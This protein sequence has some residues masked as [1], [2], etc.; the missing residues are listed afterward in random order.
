LQNTVSITFPA[1]GVTLN[2]LVEG[3]LGCIHCTEA[4]LSSEETIN[5][6][7]GSRKRKLTLDN[8]DPEIM[9]EKKKLEILETWEETKVTAFFLTSLL[10]DI[11]TLPNWQ[12]CL[13]L[14][15]EF[16]I[17]EAE[18]ERQPTCVP[19]ISDMPQQNIFP[20]ETTES[21]IYSNIQ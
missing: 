8:T 5:H 16:I 18:T 2:F 11:K 10:P 7:G 19:R 15:F 1:D 3:E 20:V 6:S 13:R 12:K 21:S 4:H 14:K 17:N 9:T